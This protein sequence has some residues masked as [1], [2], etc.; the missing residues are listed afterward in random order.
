LGFV[1][2]DFRQPPEFIP[3]MVGRS[4]IEC[5]G[6]MQADSVKKVYSF[7]TKCAIRKCIKA[8]ILA[9]SAVIGHVPW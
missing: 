7:C 2:L 1:L 6:C 4:E 9:T 5:Y 3:V 8:V